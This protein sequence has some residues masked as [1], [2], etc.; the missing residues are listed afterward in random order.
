[1]KLVDTH[2]HLDLFQDD[3][4]TASFIEMNKIYSIAVTNTPS[5]FSHTLAI[6]AGTK[7]LR[8]ALGLHPELALKRESELTLFKSFLQETRYIGEVGLDFTSKNPLEREVQ[9][10]VFKHIVELCGFEGN[11]I[12]SVH[13]R[14]AEK[15]TLDIIGESFNGKIILHYFSGPIKELKRGLS[16]GCYFSINLSM[17]N[18]RKGQ[19]IIKN[20]PIQHLLT[21]SDAPFITYTK[22][23]VEQ[24]SQTTANLGIILNY[25]TETIQEIIYNNF[26]RFLS[27]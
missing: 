9:S 6:V 15:E 10:R 8:A 11:K 12:L 7:Y 27:S 5:V 26:Q 21:E 3:T 2:L 23:I 22:G 24:I 1:M 4:A 18:T 17:T 16:Y 19:E 25:P 14:K 13:S 20:I